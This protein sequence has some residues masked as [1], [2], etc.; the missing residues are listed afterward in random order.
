VV[1]LRF[2]A[3][4]IV[5][6]CPESIFPD[7]TPDCRE[8]VAL[9]GGPDSYNLDRDETAPISACSAKK[10]QV[11]AKTRNQSGSPPDLPRARVQ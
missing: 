2:I 7:Y 8:F 4:Q 10:E 1:E 3:A 9:Y 5:R 6:F 11:N